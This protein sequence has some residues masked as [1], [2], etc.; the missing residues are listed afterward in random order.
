MNV[1]AVN[2]IDKIEKDFEYNVLSKS[3]IFCLDYPEPY[4]E[5]HDI[6]DI[7]YLSIYFDKLIYQN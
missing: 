6:A 1:S 4:F 5:I 2:K 3:E 7:I